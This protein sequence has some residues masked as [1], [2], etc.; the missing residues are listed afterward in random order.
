M[1][2]LDESTLDL[3]AELRLLRQ[4]IGE[5]AVILTAKVDISHPAVLNIKAA[6]T[7]LGTTRDALYHLLGKG[8]IPYRRHSKNFVF[9][10]A[11]LD[12]WLQQLPGITVAQAI[13]AIKPEHLTMYVRKS[14]RISHEDPDATAGPP[15]TI[16]R[17]PRRTLSLP[18]KARKEAT[19]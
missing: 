14:V 15:I 19:I 7:Y 4:A 16:T 5:L 11:D 2:G 8:R 6:A 18:S 10:K 1:N 13:K 12:A 9:L 17:G 3:A